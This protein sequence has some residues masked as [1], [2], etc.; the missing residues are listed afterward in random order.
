MSAYLDK[1][2]ADAELELDAVGKRV[3]RLEAKIAETALGV[4]L[5]EANKAYLDIGATV[6]ALKTA[7]EQ[8]A[9][10]AGETVRPAEGAVERVSLATTL[11]V[12]QNIE[13][14]QHGGKTPDG[15]QTY[16]GATDD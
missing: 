7:R 16:A 13:H 2:I 15:R 9:G 12:P 11:G 8:R 14:H 4:Q 6:V 3:K 10:L 5:S 1:M